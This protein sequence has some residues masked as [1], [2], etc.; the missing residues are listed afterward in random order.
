[1]I[2]MIQRPAT[3]R[4][5]AELIAGGRVGDETVRIHAGTHPTTAC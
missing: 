3:V 5:Q 1:M 2:R 4:V